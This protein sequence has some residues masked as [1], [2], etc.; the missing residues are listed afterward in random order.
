MTS[1]PSDLELWVGAAARHLSTCERC[2]ARLEAVSAQQRDTSE[3]LAA[4][5]G[6]PLD[7]PPEVERRVAEA[8]AG[9]RVVALPTRP[10]WGRFVAGAG[11]A[12]AAVVVAGV[13]VP[14]VLGGGELTEVGSSVSTPEMSGADRDAAGG[15]PL[16]P[17]G[18]EAPPLPA[19]VRAAAAQ[20]VADL[21]LSSAS[22]CGA[23]LA[24][25]LQGQVVATGPAGEREGVLVV[26]STA[27]G[28][29]AWW[30][31]T[32]AATVT[33]ALGTAALP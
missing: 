1:H 5:L 31:P 13:V 19:D 4:A 16:A 7:L 33:S 3:R 9:Q 27:E 24:E 12:A 28:T 32:C 21:P 26:V 10:R 8:L 29:R 11:V 15:A 17:Q 20:L 6:G 18:A 25:E 22:A 30:L 23:A 2:T 14:Q